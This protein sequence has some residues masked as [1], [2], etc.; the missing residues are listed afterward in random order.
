MK[1][2]IVLI[3]KYQ[4]K[5]NILVLL[6]LSLLL[7]IMEAA[8]VG[9]IL[10]FVTL[11]QSP[12]GVVGTKIWI[13][14]SN[15]YGKR[16]PES[17]VL[18]AGYTLLGLFIVKNI[19]AAIQAWFTQSFT[20][21]FFKKLSTQLI[22][23]YMN[24]PFVFFLNSNISILTK[25]VT[26]ETKLVAEQLIEPLILI[27]TEVIVSLAIIIIL[28]IA[29]PLSAIITF[30][31]MLLILGVLFLLT[32]NMSQ[33]L[34]TIR[35]KT[36]SKMNKICHEALA[37]IKE[38]KVYGKES[39]FISLYEKVTLIH[40]RSVA[41]QNTIQQM[42]RMI[43]ETLIVT[44][45]LTAILYFQTNSQGYNNIIALLAM[46][47]VAAYRL[48]PSANRIIASI[49]RLKYLESGFQIIAPLIYELHG[50]KM[51]P[52]SD[53][54][55]PYLFDRKIAMKEVAVKYEGASEPVLNNISLEITKGEK[56]G[57][58]G[59]SGV[60]KSTLINTMLGLLPLENGKLIIDDQELES[61]N[62]RAW[63]NLVAYV[64]Q[65]V[66]IFDDTIKHNIAIGI[67]DDEINME[68]LNKAVKIAQL[69]SVIDSSIEGINTIVGDRGSRL[70]GGQIQRI[71]IARAIYRNSPILILDEA[72][73]ALDPET[74]QALLDDL[75]IKRKEVTIIIIAHRY[76]SLRACDHIYRMQG[77]KTLDHIT[78]Q[79][80]ESGGGEII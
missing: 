1:K 52:Q 27:A 56:I 78:Y 53:Q 74:E 35:E 21:G 47:L 59:S 24:R 67:P 4:S 12:Q 2:F 10:P 13:I 25:N 39:F 11:L 31:F 29:N 76:S 16:S 75:F 77:G 60:G 3:K 5:K 18:L 6:F 57:I 55:E 73:N 28:F 68:E 15:I 23:D 42:P 64:P 63:Q 61:H 45:L 70:S 58:I 20:Q 26:M 69:H 33:R 38:I 22:E 9:A 7:A 80:L 17:V 79:E 49:M 72:T 44:T 48:M 66:F 8:G 51:M 41:A 34:G 46:Y 40:A 43:I 30:L 14:L 71:G 50:I 54:E 19:L 36:F 32:T 62:I 65:N 37:G